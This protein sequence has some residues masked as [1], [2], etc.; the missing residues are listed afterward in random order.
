MPLREMQVDGSDL[1]I[2]MAE[3]YLNGAQVGSGFEQVRG[4]TMPQGVRMDLSVMET[5]SFSSDLAGAP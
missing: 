2:S 4:E 5:G 3:Q 1:E